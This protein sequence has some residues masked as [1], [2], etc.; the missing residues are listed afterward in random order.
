MYT[1]DYIKRMINQLVAALQMIIGLK[2]AGQYG[3]ALQAIDQAFEQLLGLKA[4]LVR[5]LSDEAIL[6]SLS[7]ENVLDT[8]RLLIV[9]DLFKE[10]GDVYAALNRNAESFSSHLRALNFYIE[11]ALSDT[12]DGVTET[13]DKLDDLYHQLNKYH[14]PAGTLYGLL[15]YYEKTGRYKKAASILNQLLDEPAVRDEVHREA[16]HF[17]KRLSEKTDPELEKGELSRTVVEDRLSKFGKD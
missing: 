12:Q 2:A 16:F 17:Y 11:A 1:Q 13:N 6:N 7:Q 4:D 8:E 3:Q 10:E 15:V 14:L 5:R 9:A